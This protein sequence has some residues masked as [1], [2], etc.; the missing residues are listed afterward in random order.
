MFKVIKGKQ[1]LGPGEWKPVALGQMLPYQDRMLQGVY[2][3]NVDGEE[4]E[5]FYRTYEIDYNSFE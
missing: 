2:C 3:V 5:L 1:L 4:H